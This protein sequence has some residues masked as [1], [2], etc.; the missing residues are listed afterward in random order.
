MSGCVSE[1]SES[2]TGSPRLVFANDFP[3]VPHLRTFQPFAHQCLAATAREDIARTATMNE[4]EIARKPQCGSVTHAPPCRHRSIAHDGR[5]ES[6][7]AG[8]SRNDLAATDCD[9]LE[10]ELLPSIARGIEKRLG[11]DESFDGIGV[12]D[13]M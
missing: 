1:S 7:R 8:E 2:S 11:A 12:G 5:V 13:R 9:Q 3:N 6:A 4:S 10:V